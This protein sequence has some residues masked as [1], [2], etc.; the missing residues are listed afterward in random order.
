MAPIAVGAGPHRRARPV[1]R[2]D[3]VGALTCDVIVQEPPIFNATAKPP[4]AGHAAAGVWD[5]LDAVVWQW[6][7]VHG[8]V[9]H[10]QV[11]PATKK[12]RRGQQGGLSRR[13]GYNQNEDTRGMPRVARGSPSLMPVSGALW[14]PLSGA[15]AGWPCRPPR[16]HLP[17]GAAPPAAGAAIAC[18][19]SWLAGAGG[20]GAGRA[21]SLCRMP[22]L[23]LSAA[24]RGATMRPASARSSRTTWRWSTPGLGRHHFSQPASR[25][26][27]VKTVQS[28]KYVSV[29]FIISILTDF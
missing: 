10:R 5:G 24:L 7:A 17:V 21:A 25:R 26:G 6:W 15:A 4:G 12:T 23:P 2:P 19:C 9:G 27:A 16:A 3:C 22:A 8:V 20:A 28:T 14:S 18:L 13:A 1:D 29:Q 11:L